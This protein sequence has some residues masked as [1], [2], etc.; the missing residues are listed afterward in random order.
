MSCCVYEL[1]IIKGTDKISREGQE[2]ALTL[3]NMVLNYSLSTK[4]I[5]IKHEY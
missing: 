2:C 4:N 1:E 3:F 5:I